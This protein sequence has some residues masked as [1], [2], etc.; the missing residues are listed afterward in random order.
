MT[1]VVWAYAIDWLDKL[2]RSY[3]AASAPVLLVKEG[4]FL[5]RNMEHEQDHGRGTEEPNTAARA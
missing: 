4:R 5:Y 1:M 3:I 2:P